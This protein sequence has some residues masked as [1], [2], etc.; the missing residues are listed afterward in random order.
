MHLFILNLFL[1]TLSYSNLWFLF[2][3][4]F[5]WT[6][7]EIECWIQQRSWTFEGNLLYR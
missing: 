6:H 3:T 1:L 7:F 5:F 2:S 4:D